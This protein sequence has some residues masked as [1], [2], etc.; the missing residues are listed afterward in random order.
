MRTHAHRCAPTP[1]PHPQVC[2]PRG[3]TA[4]SR[5]PKIGTYFPSVSCMR[6]TTD[7]QPGGGRGG[8]IGRAE[9]RF[10]TACAYD[11]CDEDGLAVR[12]LDVNGN[13]ELSGEPRGR[14]LH[15]ADG[16]PQ[17]NTDGT[18]QLGDAWM[19][20]RPGARTLQ[21]IGTHGRDV[22]ATACRRRPA[23]WAHE[24]GRAMRTRGCARCHGQWDAGR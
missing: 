2:C 7:S 18:T 11:P 21:G 20:R 14:I 22:A 24:Q 17:P 8:R 5:D 6:T 1:L 10:G 13:R 19:R 15:D 16:D 12:V 4:P 3:K 9:V 23:T